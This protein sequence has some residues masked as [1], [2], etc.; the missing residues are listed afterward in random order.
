M[1]ASTSSEVL[2]IIASGIISNKIGFKKTLTFGYLLAAVSGVA[3]TTS[4]GDSE[5]LYAFFVLLSR[6][7]M[8][9]TF[10]MTY[11]A[12]QRLFPSAILATVFG[13]VNVFARFTTVLAPMI[14]EMPKPYP[15]AIFSTIALFSCLVSLKI[16]PEK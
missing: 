2:A 16:D 4:S 7:G 8:C 13:I 11:V 14:A 10:N 6:F 15:M 12:T 1:Y 9:I 3:V 5:L